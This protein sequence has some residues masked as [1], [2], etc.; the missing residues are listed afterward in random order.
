MGVV[1]YARTDADNCKG[2]ADIG[3]EYLNG[4]ERKP[5]QA[6]CLNFD[7]KNIT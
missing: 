3:D 6:R 2:V 7:V 5:C 1:G 4:G